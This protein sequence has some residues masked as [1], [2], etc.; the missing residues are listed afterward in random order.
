MVEVKVYNES[1]NPLPK[2][3]TAGATG[4]DIMAKIDVE[5]PAGQTRLV[6][7]GLFMEIPDGYEILVFP[8]S[9]L[10][11][12]TGIRIANS[13]GKIDHDYRGEICAIVWNT[14]DVDYMVKKGEKIAQ[15]TLYQPPRFTWF[16]VYDKNVLSKTDRGAGG[17]GS[18]TVA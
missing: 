15:I 9:G 11:L 4:M 18:T 8:R 17:F 14:S 13:V 1:N 7:T 6:P 5:I 12:K 2:Y 3:E 16:Q 10:S